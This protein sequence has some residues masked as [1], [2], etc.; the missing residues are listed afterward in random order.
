MAKTHPTR[1]TDDDRKI[2]L[3][4]VMSPAWMLQ[5]QGCGDEHLLSHLVVWALVLGSPTTIDCFTLLNRSSCILFDFV[6]MG[7]H[8]QITNVDVFSPPVR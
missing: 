3:E 8:R 4:T 7:N 6:S 5:L 2:R 1:S